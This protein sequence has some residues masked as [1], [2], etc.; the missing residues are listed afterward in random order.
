MTNQYDLVVLGAGP[1][2][3]VAAI[4]ASQLGLK[5]AIIEREY[6]GGVCLNIGCIPSK[7]LL[8]NAEVAHTLQHRARE[9]GFSFTDLQ[10]DY[11]VAFKRSRQVSSRLVKGVQF[12][13]KKN[14]IDVFDG[15]GKLTDANTIQISLNDG[16]EQTVSGK[17]III[18]T[19]ARPR[20]IPGLDFDGE[21]IISYKDAILSDNPPKKLII[22]GGGVIGVEFTYMWANYGVDVTIIEMMDR[23]LPNEEP[24]ISSVLEKAYKKLKV[25]LHLNS[26][27][28]KIETTDDGVAVAL[29]DGTK[30][31]GDKVMLA[32][33]FA[34][35]VENIGLESV[36]VQLTDRG[37]IAIDDQMRTNVP[38]IYA[39][40]DVATEY[41]LA[42]I[43]S[44]MGLV[45]AEAIAGQETHALDYRMM[46]RATYCVPQVASF[47]YTEAQAKEAGYEINVGQFPFQAN[48]KAL[49]LGERDGFI[50]IIADKQY[51]EILGAHMVGPDVTE[52]LPELTLAHNAELT[53][54][55]IARNV[56]AHPTLSEALMEAAHAVEGEAIHI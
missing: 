9:F 6:W 3:Y 10:L 22:V 35:N 40:G 24:E 39:I 7:A 28:D 53:A 21:K 18:A 27:V 30:L 37:A 44:A 34:P 38:N 16:G 36:G 15:T 8:K 14:K 26:R 46:P 29:A 31:E 13:M 5:V 32:I 2:G 23:L 25:K 33:N 4:R 52:L 41:R 12:L 48:G 47:G 43:A 49:G 1:G 55:E 54:E 19:G 51:G 45:A 42:H 17:N 20:S 11:S 50:K 56:H